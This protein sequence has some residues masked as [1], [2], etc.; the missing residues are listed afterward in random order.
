M[1]I[2]DGRTGKVFEPLAKGVTTR[3]GHWHR[4]GS[5][6][7]W[8]KTHP[9]SYNEGM[10]GHQLTLFRRKDK[11]DSHQGTLFDLA[12]A[13]AKKPTQK[14]TRLVVPARPSVANLQ[15]FELFGQRPTVAEQKEGPKLTYH[16]IDGAMGKA[17]VLLS[18]HEPIESKGIDLSR[19]EGTLSGN[20]HEHLVEQGEADEIMGRVKEQGGTVVKGP[21]VPREKLTEALQRKN[22]EGEREKSKE[23]SRVLSTHTDRENNVSAVVTQIEQGYSVSVRDEDSGNYLDAVTIYPTQE[24]AEKKAK[25][26][27]SG[28][29]PVIE[30]PKLGHFVR[31]RESDKVRLHFDKKHYDSLPDADKREIRS[32]FL[33]SGS[34]KA[35]V[36]RAKLSTGGTSRAEQVAQRL[37]LED[38]G[39]E[40]ERLSFA[41]RQKAVVDRAEERASRLVVAATKRDEEAQAKWKKWDWAKKDHAF[42]TQPGRIPARERMFRDDERAY[43]LTKEARELRMRAYS[44]EDTASQEQLGDRGYLQRRI[45]EN[46]AEIRGHDREFAQIRERGG[47]PEKATDLQERKRLAQEKA[48]YYREHLAKI[49]GTIHSQ[50]TVKKGDFVKIRGGLAPVLSTGP[51]NIKVRSYGLELTYPYAEIE[52]HIPREE[53]LAQLSPETRAKYLA[54]EQEDEAKRLSTAQKQAAQTLTQQIQD[55]FPKARVTYKKE[56]GFWLHEGGGRASY[57][58]RYND[59]ALKEIDRIHAKRSGLGKSRGILEKGIFSMPLSM[60]Y[61]PAA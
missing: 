52:K 49:G 3:H 19:E 36:S 45:E 24:Q 31:D 14:K 7:K 28:K 47:D 10:G 11:E 1:L 37:G 29:P 26:I 61:R 48:D 41:E 27:V 38:R 53:A 34:Q 32:N 6:L 35:W 46:E 23:P 51:K 13:F 55:R 15:Q 12:H 2:R 5:Q 60:I 16:E 57:L 42:L 4:Y 21:G 43:D 22:V 58:A 44:A 59:D 17:R 9:M 25:E 20:R 33:W 39:Q 50:A 8:V 18:S 40:G 54:S 56:S 30:K